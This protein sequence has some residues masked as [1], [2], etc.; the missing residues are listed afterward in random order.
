MDDYM[1]E[2]M[3]GKVGKQWKVYFF[4]VFLIWELCIYKCKSIH[5]NF[6]IFFYHNEGRKRSPNCERFL[7]GF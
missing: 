7:G 4:F 5:F 2:I 6:F 1:G 3:G